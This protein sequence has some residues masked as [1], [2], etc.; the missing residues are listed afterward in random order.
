MHL[1]RVRIESL[2][3]IIR[4]ELASLAPLNIIHGANGSGKSSVIEAI[5]LLATGRSFRTANPK[6]YIRYQSRDAL[7]Y[8][9]SV[10]HRIGLNKSSDN[11]ATLR[12]NGESI[13]QSDIARILPVQLINPESMDLLESGSKP[14][15]QLLDWLMFHVEHNFH[16][17]WLRYQR[18]LKQRNALL[19][20]SARPAELLVWEQE[21]A[22]TGEQIHRIRLEIANAWSI[23]FGEIVEEL[24]PDQGIH[25]EYIPAFDPEKGLL[26]SLIESR[27]RDKER[28]HSLIG[29]H[30]ADLR[31][32]THFGAA[33]QTLSRG[34]KKLLILALKL[35]QIKML[36]AK[37]C[38]SVVLLD[39]ITAELDMS[40]QVRLITLLVALNS[41]IFMTTV[42][43]SAVLVALQN[44]VFHKSLFHLIDG[45]LVSPIE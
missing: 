28:G 36:H 17:L 27:E 4:M 9:E 6:H 2:R 42:D 16:N 3:N 29:I 15:R 1:N 14:R 45:Q 22:V 34:Q 18:A 41:Q 35:S 39:D 12:L 23:I 43:L 25:F 5:H 26:E 40:A 13:S 30:R 19:K 31:F 21:M 7:V 33:E 10:D 38:A 37:G 8:A 24:L 20:R 44:V 32:R 11:L